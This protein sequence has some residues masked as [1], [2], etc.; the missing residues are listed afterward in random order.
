MTELPLW[1]SIL[2]KA[3]F[4]ATVVVSA[5]TMAEKSGPLVA[6]LIIAMPVSVGPTYVM[7]ALTAA[8]DFVAT[9]A[10]GSVAAN[11][12]VA[13]FG[14][15]YI[16]LARRLSMPLALVLALA[17]CFAAAWAVQRASSDGWT[18]VAISTAALVAG[19]VLTRSAAAGRKLL[20]GAKR[21]YDLPLRASFVGVFAG[22]LVTLCHL[23]GAEWTGLLAAFPLVLTTSIILMHPRVGSA[24]TSAAI[25]TAIQGMVAYPLGFQLVH[26]FSVSWGPWWALLAGLSAVVAWAALVYAWRAPRDA[27]ARR[28]L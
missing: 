5:T 24:A 1:L 17:T 11:G 8:P 18:L 9:S 27:A 12:A 13:V 4:A 2:V 25:A 26:L 21:W 19:S 7:L 6:G 10:L 14:T 16:L 20:A 3:L 28:R 15:A 23:I 22:T